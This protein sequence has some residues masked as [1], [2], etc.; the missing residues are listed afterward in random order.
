[1]IGP[2]KPFMFTQMAPNGQQLGNGAT[3][4]TGDALRLAGGARAGAKSPSECP[5]L[6]RTSPING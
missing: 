3:T 6:I 2:I 1:M 5:T 4:P